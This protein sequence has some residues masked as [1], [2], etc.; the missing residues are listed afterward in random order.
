MFIIMGSSM[1]TLLVT[2]IFIVTY[3]V[4][5]AKNTME[6]VMSVVSNIV[7]DGSTAALE[8]NSATRAKELLGTLSNKPS[9]TIACIYDTRQEVLAS[10]FNPEE[11]VRD[12][13][14]RC[15]DITFA[16]EGA[17][18]SSS[19]FANYRVISFLGEDIGSIYLQSN[20][21]EIRAQ[22]EVFLLTILGLI[23]ISIIGIYYISSRMQRIISGPIEDLVTATH[24][25][26]E[27]RNYTVRVPKKGN[28]ELGSL[29]DAYNMMLTQIKSRDDA[30]V[31]AKRDLES[32][33][34]ERTKDLQMAKDAAERANQ[35][36]SE[37]L[38][39]MSHELR[40][41]MH[42]ILSF[43][44]FGLTDPESNSPEEVQRFF[45]NIHK[46][47]QRLIALINNLLDLSKLDAG[48]ME[49]NWQRTSLEGA[50]EQV[51]R[52]IGSLLIEKEITLDIKS[53]EK[54]ADHMVIL[55]NNRIIQVI[56]NLVSNAIKFSPEKEHIDIIIENTRIVP[57]LFAE[58]EEEAENTKEKDEEKSIQQ[59]VP[60]VACHVRDRGI[61]IPP[62]ELQTIFQ[63][64][65]QSSKTK[66][67]AGGT[68]LGLA[69]CKNIIQQHGGVIYANNNE[70]G[71]GACFSFIIPCKPPAYLREQENREK[72]NN[73]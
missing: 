25:I 5:Q 30:L 14:A 12:D 52:E 63:K 65:I 32:K 62:E 56:Y 73:N 26:S 1:I 66:T 35:A 7:G 58:E 21:T 38:A 42:A 45:S 31:F 64:F 10:Y 19:N 11:F 16:E 15:P 29:V 13:V 51:H 68:G 67:D 39:N 6:E 23:A 71:V 9:I 44:N 54:E 49:F 46:S 22:I 34:V 36:K 2:C 18:F 17:T 4:V 61:G 72:Q 43:S 33:V 20:L 55:D 3:N 24:K 28:D 27:N 50:V 37:F 48:M 69:I 47:G 41:P 53:K 60:A 70:D 59:E 57:S 40:T 8:F